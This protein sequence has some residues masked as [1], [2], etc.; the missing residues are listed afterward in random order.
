MSCMPLLRLHPSLLTDPTSGPQGWAQDL[1]LDSQSILPPWRVSPADSWHNE[2]KSQAGPIRDLLWDGCNWDRLMEKVFLF[3]DGEVRHTGSLSYCVEKAHMPKTDPGLS[4]T[5]M[6][7]GEGLAG[8]GPGFS[9]PRP[10]D[11]PS[12]CS[13]GPSC[14]RATPVFLQ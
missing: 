4:Q 12:S 6:K 10:L 13:C 8:S 7:S 11:Q 2:L 3:G 14:L 9:P 5:K 1:D